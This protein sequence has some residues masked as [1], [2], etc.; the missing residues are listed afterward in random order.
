MLENEGR[1]AT[2]GG[3]RSN[4]REKRC[5]SGSSSWQKCREEKKA[6]KAVKE[7]EAS[8]KSASLG[9]EAEEEG[10][11]VWLPDFWGISGSS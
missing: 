2:L 1:K 5:G 8:E 7:K 10:R 4:P 6:S 11:V 9:I 3:C